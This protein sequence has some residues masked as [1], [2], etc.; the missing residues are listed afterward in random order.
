MRNQFL[1][2]AINYYDYIYVEVKFSEYKDSLGMNPF[3]IIDLVVILIQYY[4]LNRIKHLVKKS[5]SRIPRIYL[6]NCVP[7]NL[8]FRDYVIHYF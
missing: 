6:T 2:N 4:I 1:F 7:C 5:I 8:T 3:K